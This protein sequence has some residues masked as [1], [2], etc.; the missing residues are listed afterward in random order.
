MSKKIIIGISGASGAVYARAILQTLQSLE[1]ET[2]L[3]IS[4][5]AEITIAHELNIS[6][7]DIVSL[8]SYS[9]N[10]NDLSSKIASGSFKNMG[11]IVIP[12][13]MR[14]LGEIAAGSGNN[15]LARAADVT[16]KER[17]RLVLVARETPLSS[18]HLRNMLTLSEVGAIIAPALPAFYAKPNSIEEMVNHS[19]GRLLD[20]FDL[21]CPQ[22]PRW[23]GK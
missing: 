20:L 11:M 19:V 15:L 5:A 7:K 8:A 2:H 14:S 12:C 16:L 22:T 13:S 9:Y 1:I 10:Y 17:R 3:V 23:E 21:E 6:P 4:G 18:I